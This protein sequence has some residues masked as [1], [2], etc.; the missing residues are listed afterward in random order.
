MRLKKPKKIG[1]LAL[2]AP[3]GQCHYL[4]GQDQTVE[5]TVSVRKKESD[6]H[7]SKLNVIKADSTGVP[8][9]TAQRTSTR[10]ARRTNMGPS[11]RWTMMNSTIRIYPSQLRAIA[12]KRAPPSQNKGLREKELSKGGLAGTFWVQDCV[13]LSCTLSGGYFTKIQRDN[14]EKGSRDVKACDGPDEA[15]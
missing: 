6:A 10:K 11:N 8:D 15:P 1:H 3:A 5:A 13:Q 4:L 14:V 9:K 12:S 2:A 7:F